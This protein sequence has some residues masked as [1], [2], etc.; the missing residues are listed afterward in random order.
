MIRYIY[1]N[2][3]NQIGTKLIDSYLN[4]LKVSYDAQNGNLKVT[5]LEGGLTSDELETF[6]LATTGETY[7]TKEII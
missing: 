4:D 2:C 1:T 7:T 6:I 3:F 5:L